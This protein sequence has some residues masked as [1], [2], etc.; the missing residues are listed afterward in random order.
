MSMN[1]IIGK[2]DHD[3]LTDT[4]KDQYVRMPKVEMANAAN[5][6]PVELQGKPVWR[7]KNWELKRDS[8]GTY[9]Y[10]ENSPALPTLKELAMQDLKKTGKIT[11]PDKP[12]H[13]AAFAWN[14]I[15]N[16]GTGDWPK[17][18]IP[19]Y[20][21]GREVFRGLENGENLAE[22]RVGGNLVQYPN[23]L[24]CTMRRAC[25]R[26]NIEFY[27]KKSFG[28]HGTSK[29]AN[30]FCA[31]AWLDTYLKICSEHTGA[32]TPIMGNTMAIEVTHEKKTKTYPV[33]RL[34]SQEQKMQHKK[35]YNP[36]N[37]ED[38]I[39]VAPL[40]VEETSLEDCETET[41]PTVMEDVM[42]G[43]Y[44]SQEYN[45]LEEE[46]NATVESDSIAEMRRQNEELS[47]R[48]AKMEKEATVGGLFRKAIRATQNMVAKPF[49]VIAETIESNEE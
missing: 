10:L 41:E 7:L 25:M 15:F 5:L 32:G 40:G 29:I 30:R 8:G 17:G 11:Y 34:Y 9:V 21:D 35:T 26:G 24:P 27:E 42:D 14:E 47:R 16:K 36:K 39:I 22:V 1:L 20:A 19:R 37:G 46:V 49:R 6:I 45:E 13:S 28:N 23:N 44:A 33:E 2:K 31:A 3:L 48:M 12:T 43:K 38:E 18:K 4:E